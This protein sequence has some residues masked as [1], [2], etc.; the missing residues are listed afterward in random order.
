HHRG[1]RGAA[2]RVHR[3]ERARAGAARGQLRMS[4][5]DTAKIRPLRKPA[6]ADR[7]VELWIVGLNH[8]TA[9]VEVREKVAIAEAA[10]GA[11][12][13]RAVESVPLREAVVLSTCNR[14]E[15]VGIAP[16]DTDPVDAVL[17]FLGEEREIP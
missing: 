7:E 13:R 11:A 14:V 6:A 5:R 15:L 8:R 17:R 9:P 3:R 16:R 2:R 4:E 12:A 10:L 1:L